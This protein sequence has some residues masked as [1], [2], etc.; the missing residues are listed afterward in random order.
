MKRPLPTFAILFACASIAWAAPPASLTTLRAIHALSNA[1][2]S[3]GMPVAFEAT[4]TY[5]RGYESTLFVQD[6]DTAIYVYYPTD[7][8]LVPGDR[9]LVR[10]KT[11]GSFNPIV[12]A[13]SVTVLR[14]GALPAPQL[15]TFDQ[16]IRTETDCKLVTVRAVVHAAD[17]LLSAVA[18]EHFIRLE[19]LMDGG[20]FNANVDSDNAG[21]P[22]SLLDAEVELTGVASEEFDSKMHET[23]ILMHIQ[24]LSYVKIIQ[25]AN[26]DPWSL[27]VTPMDR[28]ITVY[29]LRNSTPRIRVHGTITYYQ[30]G[31]AVVLQDGN[32]SI[33]IATETHKPLRI[34]D[35]ADATGFPDVHDGF[36]NLTHG[37][38]RDS[39][40]PAP[41]TP[42]PATWQTLTPRGYDSPGHHLDLVSIE[43]QV[44]TEVREASQDELVLAA[45]GKQ[46]S[47]ILRHPN[48]PLT[49]AREIPVGTRVRVTG[50]CV[51]ELSNPFIA[52]VPFNILLRSNDDITVVAKP[53]LLNVRNLTIVVCALILIVFAVIARGWALEHNVRRQ[54]SALAQLE[55]RRGHILEDI[56][57]SRPLA[58][59]LEQI[60]DLVAFQLQGAPCWCEVTDG[61]RLG[62]CPP[63][64][65][66]QR[67][68]QEK[69]PARAGPPLGAIYVAFDSTTKPSTTES[70]AL[71]MAAGLA[72]LAIETRRLYSDLLHRS[73]FDQLTD[74]HNRFSLEKLLDAQ[75]DAARFKA[76]IF[77]LIYIDLDNFKLVNDSHGHQAGDQYLQQVALRLKRQLRPHDRL[78]RLG[79]DE[80]AALVPLVRSRAEVEE[81]AQRVERCLDDPF[82]VD[83]LEL[84]GSA[85][86]GIALYPE[87]GVTRDELLNVADV[88]MYSAKNAKRQIEKSLSQSLHSEL[89]AEVRA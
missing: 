20:Y 70:E 84:T 16:M 59:I 26:S 86:V 82:D 18:D 5:Y 22:E 52:Q 48:G 14:H 47:A 4:V 11:Q 12:V 74:I 60:T 69:I 41:I 8:H 13:D 46:F 63:Q 40:M 68:A 44:V 32:K 66:T 25:R 53:S 23:G 50:I 76:T 2:A 77:G 85:S 83:G 9:V 33:W 64:L 89:T 45:D 36:I 72:T 57:G 28:A 75:I 81:I 39:M 67:V 21:A 43:G 35:A 42:L 29:H 3:K 58:E 1:E 78:A 34:G 79:G 30:P 87:D 24:S 62:K 88:A 17:L 10:G 19:L 49:A 61:A 51:L 31:S 6:G 54:T 80:F 15:V 27:P 56:N 71:S 65:A 38:I 37:E 73:E 55:Q 7:L